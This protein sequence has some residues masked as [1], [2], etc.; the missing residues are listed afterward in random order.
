MILFTGMLV[1][2][3]RTLEQLQQD[4][5]EL[6]IHPTRWLGDSPTRFDTYKKYAS[7]VDTIVEFGV[8]TGLSTCAWLAGNPKKLRS[9]DITDSHLSVLDELKHCAMQKNIDFEFAIAN[10]LEIDIEPCDL[11][12]IDTVHTKPHCLAELDRHNK[13]AGRYIILHD[14]TAWPGVFEAVITFLHHNHDW[15]I[16]EH[17]NKGSGLL[18]LE[19]YA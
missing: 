2:I 10:S 14:P 7:L 15:H 13:H 6:K 4:F 12:F 17:C 9:Y 19:R 1:N 16:V 11:L 3:M 18:V 8:Y 5:V